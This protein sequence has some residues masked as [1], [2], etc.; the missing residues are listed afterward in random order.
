MLE[1][2]T[3]AALID[4]K[5]LLD[6]S[7]HDPQ[8]G[9]MRFEARATVPGSS[10]SH[11]YSGEITIGEMIISC[12]LKIPTAEVAGDNFFKYVYGSPSGVDF[13]LQA[14]H[15]DIAKPQMHSPEV[16]VVR[17][18]R[19]GSKGYLLSLDGEL[20]GEVGLLMLEVPTAQWLDQRVV[21]ILMDNSES[22]SQ[23]LTELITKAIKILTGLQRPAK[24]SA[25]ES[26]QPDQIAQWPITNGF[27][28]MVSLY[29]GLESL[30][31]LMADVTG[32]HLS[33]QY[34]SQTDQQ[35]ARILRDSFQRIVKN[36]AAL[37][38][39]RASNGAVRDG[40][41]DAKVQNFVILVGDNALAPEIV[42]VDPLRFFDS[43]AG[44]CRPWHVRDK[45][46]D[47]AFLSV[48]AALQIAKAKGAESAY[49]FLQ[50]LEMSNTTSSEQ[51]VSE[52]VAF[53]VY[54]LYAFYVQSDTLL[55]ISLSAINAGNYV[56]AQAYFSEV[57]LVLEL[58]N[59]YAQSQVTAQT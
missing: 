1:R 36:N 6:S 13:A 49:S 45:Q 53:S 5:R 3:P 56:Q 19:D 57:S 42:A 55:R 39:E 7:L 27:E 46:W 41:G 47:T 32:D 37:L 20:D 35:R 51:N 12:V 24:A 4:S 58:G 17:V 25:A 38:S 14:A 59:I 2:L 9:P 22:W 30:E 11:L 10:T 52:K 18:T 34:L 28:R 43:Q 26:N 29:E 23:E 48:T 40:H 33:T 16:A 54:A 15:S 21:Q 8:K 44:D 31:K 50:N